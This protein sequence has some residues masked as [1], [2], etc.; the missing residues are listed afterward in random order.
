M[1]VP[2]AGVGYGEDNGGSSPARGGKEIFF[3]FTTASRPVQ[4]SLE[5]ISLWLGT[6]NSEYTLVHSILNSE[7]E[8]FPTF[9]YMIAGLRTV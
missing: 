3:L 9:S 5:Y 4:P 1:C 7:T 8:I 2:R 6:E